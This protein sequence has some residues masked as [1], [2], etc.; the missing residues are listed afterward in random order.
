MA[1]DPVR[2]VC[3]GGGAPPARFACGDLGTNPSRF[4]CA[5]TQSPPDRFHALWTWDTTTF[6]TM[7]TDLVTETLDVA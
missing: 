1:D 6:L 7:D 2:Y 3:G 5:N 4:A